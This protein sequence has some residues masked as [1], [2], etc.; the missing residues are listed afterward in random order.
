MVAF[1]ICANCEGRRAKGEGRVRCGL[2]APL[3]LPGSPRAADAVPSAYTSCRRNVRGSTIPGRPRTDPR[4]PAWISWPN[5]KASALRIALASAE[6]LWPQ[7]LCPFFQKYAASANTSFSGEGTWL[8][9]SSPFSERI[10][11]FLQMAFVVEK[12]GSNIVVPV[13]IPNAR[14][15]STALQLFGYG[16]TLCALF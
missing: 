10:L 3:L 15:P 4:I 1:F 7:T 6:V 13:L 12:S 11:Y 8:Q 2:K 16:L 5:V 14:H 9:T